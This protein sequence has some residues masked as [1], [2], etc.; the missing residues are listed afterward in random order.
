[1]KLVAILGSNHKSI[2]KK[3]LD[4][5]IF[6]SFDF[7][8]IEEIEIH[9]LPLFSET[10]SVNSYPEIIELADKISRSDGVLIVTS[11]YN[12]TVPAV[13]KNFLEWMSHELKPFMHKPVQL[14]GGSNNDQGSS[15][16]QVH[17]KQILDSPGL[18]CFVMPANE[19]ILSNADEKFDE[20]GRLLDEKTADYLE[21][22]L[23]KFKKYIEI[24]KSLNF[25]DLDSKYQMTL[26]A[27]GY[28]NLDDPHG[29]GFASA[30]EY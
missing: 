20:D 21:H 12:H 8:M 28:I 26:R 27:G 16:A 3:L 22:I 1:M 11:E 19:F 5:T 14:I 15:R 17:L 13:L 9:N 23:L 25:D 29:D 6:S 18:D 10:L 30:S 2:N 7:F 4:F 24:N